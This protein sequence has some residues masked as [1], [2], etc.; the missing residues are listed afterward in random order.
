MALETIERRPVLTHTIWGPIADREL[1]QDIID[2]YATLVA[3]PPATVFVEDALCCETDLVAVVPFCK[4]CNL[5]LLPGH[6][7]ECPNCG[8]VREDGDDG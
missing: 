3:H 4:R 5:P 6:A 8:L 7:A 1:V 2:D